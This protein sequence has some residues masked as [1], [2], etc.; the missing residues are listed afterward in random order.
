[1]PPPCTYNQLLT[2]LSLPAIYQHTNFVSDKY[3]KK[4]LCSKHDVFGSPR[5]D[6]F[7]DIPL[8]VLTH[9]PRGW[10]GPLES[11]GHKAFA[12]EIYGLKPLCSSPLPE[13]ALMMRF[14]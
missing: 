7:S 4:S 13:P 14:Q 5:S 6:F 2:T 12:R 1:M 11:Y 9:P 3:G 8:L 10:G